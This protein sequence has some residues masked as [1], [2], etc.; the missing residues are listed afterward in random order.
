MVKVETEKELGESLKRGEDIIEIEGDLGKK[1]FRIKATGKVAWAVCFSA[2]AVA[3]VLIVATPAT[4]GVAA[5]VAGVSYFVAVP[6]IVSTIG[7][8]A[9]TAAVAIAVAGGGVGILNKLRKYRLTKE[10]D[11]VILIK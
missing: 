11:K 10:G 1:V 5:P 7:I 2:L 8:P 9:A 6:V 4:V 3:I